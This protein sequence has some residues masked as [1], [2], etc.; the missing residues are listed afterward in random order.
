MNRKTRRLVALAIFFFSG[1]AGLVYEVVWARQLSLTLGVSVYAVTA[2]L[3]AFMGGLGL[4]AEFF[5]RALDKGAAPIRLYS[6]LEICLGVYALLFPFLLEMMQSTYVVL[7]GGAQ[8][9]TLKI[10]VLRFVMAVSVMLFPTILMGGTLPAMVR[11]FA[12]ERPKGYGDL[13]GSLYALNTIGAL[14]GCISAGFV[15]IE[16]LGLN[17]AMRVGALVNITGGI[18]AW[19]VAAEPGW[20]TQ[21]VSRQARKAG[22]GR[23]AEKP[24]VAL[25]IAYG[26]TGFCALALEV[27]WTRLLIL[28][29]S[30]T[31]YAFTLILAAI[32]FGIGVGSA[33]ASHL[34]KK[35]PD[36]ALDLFALF[37]LGVGILALWSFLLFSGEWNYW[38]T[39]Q[40]HGGSGQM[41]RASLAPGRSSNG[42]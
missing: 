34:L 2:V 31:T 21:H 22:R 23:P 35:W 28:Q 26:V 1:S 20:K 8:G 29:L 7:H 39:G 15:M 13:A 38:L 42:I 25:L 36:S 9:I 37:Q 4:G 12:D 41:T 24:D 11:Y 40:G 33:V 18:L 10:I 32:L 5:G 27:I 6:V 3:V 30:N 14:A 17:G 16:S 19:L